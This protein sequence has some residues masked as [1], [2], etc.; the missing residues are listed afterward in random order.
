MDS[1][2]THQV[3]ASMWQKTR[4][5]FVF[6]MEINYKNGSSLKLKEN[7]KRKFISKN[8]TIMIA[9]YETEGFQGLP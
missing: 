6:L 7:F 3:L 5:T 2:T 1:Q 8:G 4:Y 9:C